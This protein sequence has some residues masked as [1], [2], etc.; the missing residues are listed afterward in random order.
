MTLQDGDIIRMDFVER[1][2]GAVVDTTQEEVAK[3]NGIFDEEAE[4]QPRIILIGAGQ[5]V[6]GLEEDLLGKD[7]GYSGTVSI[8]P[9]KAYGKHDPEKVESVSLSKFKEERPHVGM[10]VSLNGKNGT[11]TRIIGRKANVD[12]NHPLAGK[13]IEFEYNIVGQIEDRQEKLKAIITTFARADL[14]C[15]IEG[16]LAEINVPWELGYYRDWFTIRRGI[17]D[18]IL[19][20]LNLNEVR[21]IEKHTGER[22]KAEMISPPEREESPAE[23][24]GSEEANPEA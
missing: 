8:P 22:V 23:E 2:D 18:M 15:H 13:P 10:R 16:D 11:V 14:E 24:T 3:E 17:A 20:Y 4:Y 7:V 12:L 9:E 21:Y 19:N 1:A 5:V 6:A